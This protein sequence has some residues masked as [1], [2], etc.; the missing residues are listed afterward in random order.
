MLAYTSILLLLPK[1][2]FFG[3]SILF[4]TKDALFRELVDAGL[5][6][7]C[8]KITTLPKGI[9]EKKVPDFRNKFSDKNLSKILQRRNHRSII[10]FLQKQ[11]CN[12]LEYDDPTDEP[13]LPEQKKTVLIRKTT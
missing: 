5:Y 9:K 10:K 12:Y 6:E 4:L 13:Y 3:I 11:V 1:K 8:H 2:R 7:E